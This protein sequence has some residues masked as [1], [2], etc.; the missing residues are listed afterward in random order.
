LLFRP[1]LLAEFHGERP[2]GVALLLDNSQSMKQQ[3]RRLSDTDK[4]RVAIAQNLVPPRTSMGELVRVPSDSL[5][6]PPRVELVKAVLSHPE[7]KLLE[8]LQKHGPLRPYLFGQRLRGALEETTTKSKAQSQTKERL[9]AALTVDEGRTGLA[10]AIQDI[11]QRKD[12][13]LPA[14]IV[15]MSDGLDN[16]SKFTLEEAARECR[17]RVPLH[18]Y[19]VG[20]TEG[21]S[22]QLREVAV[23]DT[24]FFDDT[25]SVPLRWRAQGFKEGK[26]DI[27]PSRPAKTCA[28]CSASRPKRRTRRRT[29]IST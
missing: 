9:L 20:S 10:D 23:P 6:D 12:G 7:L 26:I 15:V 21:G 19:G 28:T 29:T 3:D 22:L 17:G 13:D 4:L 2:R 24:M 14:A 1:V 8:S 25:I 18:I 11:L 16:A 5:K 27:T